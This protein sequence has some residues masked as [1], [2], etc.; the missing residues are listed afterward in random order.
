MIETPM[1]NQKEF[2]ACQIPQNQAFKSNDLRFSFG[3]NDKA[4]DSSANSRTTIIQSDQTPYTTSFTHH[5]GT[6][7]KQNL[8]MLT[9]GGFSFSRRDSEAFADGESTR[10]IRAK[11]SV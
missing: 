3:F 1:F 9:P 4:L 7:E 8:S 2:V 5:D 11:E 10:D 6:S